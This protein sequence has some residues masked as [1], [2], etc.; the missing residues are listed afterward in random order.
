MLKISMELLS[1]SDFRKLINDI[2]EVCQLLN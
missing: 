2:A 1:G